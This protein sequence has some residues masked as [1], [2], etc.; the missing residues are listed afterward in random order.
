VAR[1]LE[2]H[3]NVLHR[4]RL[5]ITAELQRRGW[6]V[7]PRRVHR[8]LREDNLLCVRKRKSWNVTSNGLVVTEIASGVGEQRRRG[9]KRAGAA[10]SLNGQ[11][12]IAV[13][14]AAWRKWIGSIILCYAAAMDSND[15]IRL[16]PL[17]RIAKGRVSD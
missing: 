3:P 14:G 6:K 5:R 10:A 17:S 7:N 1:G 15:W 12:A 11:L 16:P 9:R 8:I 2:A 4:W 13:I